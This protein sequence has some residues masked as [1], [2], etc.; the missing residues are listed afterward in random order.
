MPRYYSEI[1]ERNPMTEQISRDQRI[2]KRKCSFISS[3]RQLAYPKEFRIA[4]VEWPPLFDE[5]LKQLID[6]LLT[7]IEPPPPNENL[8]FL[9]DVATGLWRL[10]GKMLEPGTD[11]PRD[12]MRRAYRFLD[13]VWDTLTQAGVEIRDHTDEMVPEGGIYALKA[14]AYQPTPGII[15]EK[16]IETIKPSV[17]FKNQLIQMGE[18]IIGTPE[19][20]N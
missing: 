15:R 7:T 8:P 13:S 17:Y 2:A 18:V 1:F 4:A 20:V 5:T 14:I 6:L 16:V 3:M 10:R 11:R 12:E 9:A 19:Q